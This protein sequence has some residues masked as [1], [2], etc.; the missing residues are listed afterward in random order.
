MKITRN[1]L[2]LLKFFLR[3]FCKTKEKKDSKSILLIFSSDYKANKSKIETGITGIEISEKNGKITFVY[4]IFN[5]F[6]FCFCFF[7]LSRFG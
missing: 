3:D 1:L 4:C 6:C 5:V 7:F 2:I